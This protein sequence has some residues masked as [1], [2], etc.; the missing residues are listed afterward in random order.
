MWVKER[1]SFVIDYFTCT[2]PAQPIPDIHRIFI[3]FLR[4]LFYLIRRFLFL[5]SSNKQNKLFSCHQ[6]LV[7]Q[8]YSDKALA[9]RFFAFLPFWALYNSAN[10]ILPALAPAAVYLFDRRIRKFLDKKKKKNQKEGT[11]CRVPSRESRY[12]LALTDPTDF[13]SFLFPGN[14]SPVSSTRILAS[15]PSLPPSS[16]HLLLLLRSR[17]IDFPLHGWPKERP[18]EG[19]RETRSQIS[20]NI[21]DG[22]RAAVFYVPHIITRVW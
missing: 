19:E 4:R 10:H 1:E 11:V 17:T 9:V 20:R 5:S 7:Q 14:F 22:R 13:F 21:T 6:R 12:W 15:Q 8:F 18:T 2:H 16:T 3:S